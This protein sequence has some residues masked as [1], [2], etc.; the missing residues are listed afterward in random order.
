MFEKFLAFDVFFLEGE[1][2]ILITDYVGS[3]LDWGLGIALLSTATA[4]DCFKTMNVVI[5]K[6]KEW[7]KGTKWEAERE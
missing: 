6:W 2:L 7:H 3:S 1:G 5:R 4:F